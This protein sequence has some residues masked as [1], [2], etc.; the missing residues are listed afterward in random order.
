MINLSKLPTVSLFIGLPGS[1]KTS[2]AAAFVK[3]SLRKKIPVYSNVPIL[4]AYAFERSDIGSYCMDGGVIIIDEAGLEFDN[5]DFDKNFRG[6]AGKKMLSFFKLARHYGAKIIVLSQTADIDLKIR[7]LAGVIY[8][9]RRSLILGC[10]VF[11]KIRRSIGVTD[12]GHSLC[13]CFVEPKPLG[14]IFS[15][16]LFRPRVYKLFDSY[17]A[18]ALP[19]KDFKRWDVTSR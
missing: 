2:I 15:S 9:V 5:R 13:D 8:L 4:G 16:R 7:S 17:E 14:K 18:P 10:S 11:Y 19:V 1:G 6:D 3:Q 12:D